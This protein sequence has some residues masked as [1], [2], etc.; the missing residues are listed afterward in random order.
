[1][2]IRKQN[3]GKKTKRKRQ[4]NKKSKN[5]T[6]FEKKKEKRGKKNILK[7]ALTKSRKKFK[8]REKKSD[9]GADEEQTSWRKETDGSVYT[10]RRMFTRMR[11]W[12]GNSPPPRPPHAD[13]RGADGRRGRSG[14]RRL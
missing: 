9:E 14:G 4:Q 3:E 2:K 12:K 7:K 8:K 11:R 5:K 13:P 6:K 10:Q 1:M